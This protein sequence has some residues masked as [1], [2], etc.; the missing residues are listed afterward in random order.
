MVSGGV[1]QPASRMVTHNWDNFFSHLV[2]AV[3]ADALDAPDYGPLLLHLRDGWLPALRSELAR[4][5]RLELVYWICAFSVNQHASICGGFGPSPP[6]GTEQYREWDRKRHDTVTGERYPLCKCST[7]KHFNSHRDLCELNK[8]DPMMAEM[9]K[10]FPG[11][12]QIIAVDEHLDIFSRAWCIAELAEA[13]KLGIVQTVKLHQLVL[14]NT[15]R[16]KDIRVENCKASRPDDVKEILSK[17]PDASAFNREVNSLIW[18][19]ESGIFANTRKLWEKEVEKLSARGL[20]IQ[21][22][23]DFYTSLGA[24]TMPDFRPDLHTTNDVLRQVIIPQT[25][26]QWKGQAYGQGFAYTT[27]ANPAVGL[28]A[29]RYVTHWKGLFVEFIAAVIADAL[30]A[31]TYS[32]VLTRIHASDMASLRKELGTM[33]KLN[34]V[35]W[36][37]D[38]SLN[39]HA[40]ICDCFGPSPPEGTEQYREW[41]RRRHDPVTGEEH[42]VC[43]CYTVKHWTDDVL[44]CELNKDKHLI[45]KLSSSQD[46]RLLVAVDRDF[47]TLRNAWC[48]HDI[49]SALQA[50]TPIAVQVLNKMPAQSLDL[51]V[52]ECSCESLADKEFILSRIED[53]VAFDNFL[54]MVCAEERAKI[55]RGREL[56]KK[57]V[58]FS[59]ASAHTPGC[60]SNCVKPTGHDGACWPSPYRFNGA[61]QPN[62]VYTGDWLESQRQLEESKVCQG[63]RHINSEQHDAGAE[64]GASMDGQK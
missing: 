59:R 48:I 18:N 20:R 61:C 6:E 35:Y 57:F 38:F 24:T 34:L 4:L 11:M 10:R 16:C 43:G 33:G 40:S 39:F 60:V 25:V 56:I 21:Q 27:V 22:L 3:V 29:T 23:I 2:A 62:Q 64:A 45:A 5:G 15:A 13:H 26:C 55:S 30:D 8:F 54:N 12:R 1:T 50:R 14:A 17:I 19:R 31:P 37:N 32:D 44:T 41:Y 7:E 36:I 42:P 49:T 47:V 58:C 53:Y 52:H 63:Q 51:Q 9:S 28:Q 46:A